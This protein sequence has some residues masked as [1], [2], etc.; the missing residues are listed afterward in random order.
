MRAPRRLLPALLAGLLAA[1]AA[2][3]PGAGERA[4][5]REGPP[6]GAGGAGGA[7]QEEGG[8]GGEGRR[9]GRSVERGRPAL[10]LRVIDGDTVEVRFRGK[11]ED[12][13]LIGVDTP[14]TVAP[15]EPVEC[16]GREASAFTR[17]WLEG[18]EVRLEFDV[19]LRDRY[20]R[21][22]AYVWVDG[23][24]FNEVL[25]REG[26]AQ[27]ATFPPNVRYVDRFLAAQ[28]RARREGRGLWGGCPVAEAAAATGGSCDPSYP[29]VCI[30]PPPP[31]LDCADVGARGFRV[32]G[33]DPH[34]FDGD[35][36]GIGCET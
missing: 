14:E 25:V 13:R 31:D 30:P 26:Y 9:A 1:C 7:G 16:Y 36:D 28:R 23:R 8:A 24:L 17:R 15:G 12:V 21:L 32:T 18:R 20:G 4:V 10:V 11:V 5:R 34:G 3:G 2:S 19:E 22:L 27:V 33:S 35:A 6:A 29:D